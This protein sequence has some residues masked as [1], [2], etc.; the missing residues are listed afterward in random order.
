MA[1]TFATGS[2]VLAHPQGNLRL[3][4]E[5]S[6]RVCFSPF[7][8]NLPFEVTCNPFFL[9]PLAVLESKASMSGRLVPVEDMLAS[10][11][12]PIHFTAARE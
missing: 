11:I 7:C 1:S 2:E 3:R 9:N 8:S 12:C 10:W 4:G 6:F 5:S